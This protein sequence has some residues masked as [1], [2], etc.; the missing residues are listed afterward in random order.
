MGIFKC[1]HKEI[2]VID[3]NRKNRFYIV[4]CI[5]CGEQWKEPKAEGEMYD[6]FH[7]IKRGV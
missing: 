5:K 4:E 1:K 6:M 2:R 3:C 7:T